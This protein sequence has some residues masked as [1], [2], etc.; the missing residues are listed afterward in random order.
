MHFDPKTAADGAWVG[1]SVIA[2]VVA[3]QYVFLPTVVD[4]FRDRMFEL[5]RD[6]FLLVADGKIAPTD[7]AYV[8]LRRLMNGTI[9]FAERITF[10]RLCMAALFMWW[11]FG[12][13]RLAG[14]READMPNFE[15][16]PDPVAR[17]AMRRI[18]D[19]MSKAGPLYIFVS[20]PV[21]WL[22]T[23]LVA[24]VLILVGLVTG[25]I[26]RTKQLIVTE[27]S[28]RIE[29]DVETLMDPA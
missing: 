24:P 8:S 7:Q 4:C 13:E 18:H 3:F 28:D 16:I 5:R 17:T 26:E 2:L 27:V 19:E 29:C 21:A 14:M 9:R 22:L 20:S 10:V 15:S 23:I 25:T 1:L 11:R 12:P 6:L